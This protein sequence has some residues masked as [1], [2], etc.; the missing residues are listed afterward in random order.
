M[1]EGF[2]QVRSVVEYES[3][4]S[5]RDTSYILWSGSLKDEILV[6]RVQSH[7]ADIATN[8][9]IVVAEVEE[10]LVEASIHK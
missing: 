9:K 7:V 3:R 8:T 10:S 4:R 5:A 6:L 2:P 1:E